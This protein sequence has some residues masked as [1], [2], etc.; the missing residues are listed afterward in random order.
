MHNSFTALLDRDGVINYDDG[1]TYKFNPK[2]IFDDMLALTQLGIRDIFIFTNQSGIARGY[3]SESEFHH[4][5]NE[6]RKYILKE[7]GLV[8]VEY[9][10]CPHS[11]EEKCV[12]RKPS[13]HLIKLGIEKYDFDLERTFFVGDKKSDIESADA[14]GVKA[15]Y[16]INRCLENWNENEGWVTHL[17]AKQV[18]SLWETCKDL[19]RQYVS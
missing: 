17:G 16:L 6:L 1:Y 19:E 4:F 15:K 7:F 8:L 9:F 10:Y 11:P 14:A 2:I 18:R 3:Y 12:C 5:M 13:P